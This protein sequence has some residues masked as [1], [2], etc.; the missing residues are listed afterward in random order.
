[1]QKLLFSLIVLV[2]LSAFTV[3]SQPGDGYFKINTAT[4]SVKWN[5]KKVTGQHHGSITVKDGTLQMQKNKLVGGSFTIDMASIKVLDLQ[6][7]MAGKLEGH[8]KSDDFFNAATF[9]S[10]TLIILE[11]KETSKENYNI[12]ANLTIRGITKAVEFPAV[13][14]TDGK[15]YNA[16]ANITVDRSQFDVKYGSGSF[17]DNLGDK[18]IYDNFD[19]AVS[20]V[21]E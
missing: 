14:K 10:A 20:L 21:A 18:T 17:Y 7:E 15:K 16:S 2:G 11:A 5:A 19:L 8:L 6:G 1:M 3:A 9:P 12:K 4:S 13:V